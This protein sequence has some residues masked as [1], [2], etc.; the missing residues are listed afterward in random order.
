MDVTPQWHVT[1]AISR[2]GVR[3]R[4]SSSVPSASAGTGAARAC[5]LGPC[6]G[7][8]SRKTRPPGPGVRSRDLSERVAQALSGL[9]LGRRLPQAPKSGFRGH[10]TIARF[11]GGVGSTLP[12][13]F[14]TGW[15]PV[16]RRMDG[17]DPELGP[18]I[19]QAGWSRLFGSVQSGGGRLSLTTHPQ[20]DR[21]RISTVP[22]IN[23]SRWSPLWRAAVASCRDR[24]RNHRCPLPLAITLW[25]GSTIGIGFAPFAWPTARYA[26]GPPD[27]VRELRIADGLSIRDLGKR[28]ATRLFGT[29]FPRGPVEGRIP[30]SL[31]RSTPVAA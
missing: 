20:I 16:S 15:V 26:L 4:V 14:G 24:P 23:R 29:G 2:R 13:L 21:P 27:H 6:V 17:L 7:M 10:L 8:V 28:R 9:D 3:S 12:G 11:A 25:H 22:G 5:R 31:L 18:L 19:A 1:L 30:S